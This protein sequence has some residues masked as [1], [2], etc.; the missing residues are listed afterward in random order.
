M[1]LGVLI[2]FREG[3]YAVA[4]DIREMFY[5]VRTREEDQDALRFL[6]RDENQT[7]GHYVMQVMIFGATC[8]PACAQYIKN[9]NADLYHDKYPQAVEA[10]KAM[11][12]DDLLDSYHSI[13]EAMKTVNQIIKINDNAHFE[14]RNFISNN[15]EILKALPENRISPSCERK[16]FEEKTAKSERVLGVFWD[17]KSD[18]VQYKINEINCEHIPTK[19]EALSKVARVFDPLGLIAHLTIGGK[20]LMQE[21]WKDGTIWDEK[22]PQR[23]VPR[24]KQWIFKLKTA[25]KLE[26]PRCYSTKLSNPSKI[27]LHVFMDAS[28]D[29][30]AAAAA[31][32]RVECNQEVD[33]SLITAKTRVAPTKGMTIP[34]LELQAAVLGTRLA[35]TVKM[36][37]RLKFDKQVMWSDSTTVLAW[38]RSDHKKYKQFVQNRLGE[39]LES[40]TVMDWRW[41]PT[42]LNPADEATRDKTISNSIWFTSAPFLKLEEEYWPTEKVKP[43]TTTEEVKIFKID[44]IPDVKLQLNWC[45]NWQRLRKAV[46]YWIFYVR[47][48]QSK[49]RGKPYRNF[50]TVSDYRNAEILIIKQTQRESYPQD[51]ITLENNGR[52]EVNSSIAELEPTLDSDGVIRTTGRLDKARSLPYAVRHP[53]IIPNKHHLITKDHHERFLHRQLEAVIAA[54]RLNFW[55]VNTRSAVKRAF[56]KCQWCKNQKS[57]P[58]APQMGLLP[59]CRTSPSTKAFIHTGIDYFGPM[60]ITVRRSTE[61]RWGALFTCMATRA[62]HLELADDLTTDALI[63]CILTLQYRRGQ[64]KA[65]YSDNGTNMQGASNLFKALE[66]RTAS[67]GI[68]WHFIPPSAPHFGGAW[69]RMVQETKKL[70][71]QKLWGNSKPNESE[72]RLAL[73]EIE[74][75]LNSRPLT[76]IPLNVDDDEPLTPNHFLMGAADTPYPS[77]SDVNKAEASRSHWLKVQH[78]TQNFWERWT[79]EY[80]PKLMKR[81]KWRKPMEPLQ[82]DDIVVM[83]DE[84]IKGK[85]HKGIITETNPSSSG[86][87]RSVTVKFGKNQLVRPAVKLAKLDVKTPSTTVFTGH[88]NL[89]TLR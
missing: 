78:A 25:V 11:Y 67:K 59:E 30:F 62:V 3:M 36:E 71:K 79:T 33:I 85:F 68:E 35:N 14:L 22:I 57:T 34:R 18:S 83:A 54:I 49:V 27:E 89:T 44:Q 15:H 86:Q 48:L 29:A 70:L 65:F 56:A 10:I 28:E 72:L 13:E 53:I 52:V 16:E 8:S 47:K 23:L 5:Q 32:I 39:I 21:I 42:K 82:K 43:T 69:E 64:I 77:L 45:S 31:Y 26:I 38:I 55:I 74:Y 66:K 41:V 40:T 84:Q 61:K 73:T 81:E 76:H 4:G 1:I 24:W 6:F 46:G 50:V 80:L 88:I 75:L 37:T 20:L 87:V 7:M 2:R 17:I 9:K 63:R 51:L 12:V 60:E 19:R 58:Q